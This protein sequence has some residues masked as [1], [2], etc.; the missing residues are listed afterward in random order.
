M[1]DGHDSSIDSIATL[2]GKFNAQQ[3][4][5][6]TRANLPIQGVT[7][8]GP[9]SDVQRGKI[10]LVGGMNQFMEQERSLDPQGRVPNQ[11]DALASRFISESAGR[12]T[13]TATLPKPQELDRPLF[14]FPQLDPARPVFR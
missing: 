13:G 4:H 12:S 9:P 14:D 10:L 3:A 5:V 2:G 8:D 7:T 6:R 11:Q 1:F